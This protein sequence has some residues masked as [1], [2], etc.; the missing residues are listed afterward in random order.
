MR[1]MSA[2]AQP[3]PNERVATLPPWAQAHFESLQAELK[4]RE[5]K[6][7]QL[8]LELAHH[9]RLR[10]GVKSEALSPEQRDLFSETVTADGAAIAAELTAQ[11]PPDPT[12]R[13]ST[14]SGRKPLPPELPRIEHRHEPSSCTCAQCGRALVKIGEDVS[15]Q[16]DVEPARFFVHR[17]IRPQYACRT[18]ETVTAAAVAPALIDGGL[19]APGLHAWVLIQKYLD[20]LPLYRIESISARQGVPIARSTLA[21]WVGELGVRLEPLYERLV[22]LLKAGTVLHADETPVQQL[23]P[24]AG[25][26]KRAYLW[27]Y[28]S[29]DLQRS[30]PIAVFD[31]QGSR[32]GAHAR[33]FLHG[34]RGHLMVDDFAGYKGL[35][36][37]AITELA[38]LAHCR[39]KFFDLHAAGA[40]PVA[41][42]VLRRIAELYAIEAQARA[43]PVAERLVLRQAEAAPRLAA[44]YDYLSSHRLKTAQ[45]SGLAR[46]IDYSLKRWAALQRYLAD[47]ALP[48]DNNPAEN[49]IRPIALGRKNW[50]FVGS[51]RAGRRAATI[52]SLLA[53]AK[54][55]GIEPHAWLKDTLEKLP[56]WPHSRIDE[57]LPLAPPPAP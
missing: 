19:A 49:A 35:F 11:Q 32:S 2:A 48:I 33:A 3:A 21:Q 9:K 22:T 15:E 27:A 37:A 10:F 16:L 8:T 40:H 43:G 54:L 46:A 29:N 13:R 4:L 28:R 57:L 18:C 44:L 52:Q 53:T 26:T 7:Q 1:A 50:L 25:K 24:G 6:I 30:P 42:E 38:C 34:W 39:R 14:P 12:P 56:T 47:G 41:A 23:D 55:N 45:G 20:H 31:Y 17:H 51:E 5:L 36:G